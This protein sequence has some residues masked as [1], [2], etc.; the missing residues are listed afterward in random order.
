VKATDDTLLTPEQQRMKLIQDRLLAVLYDLS[1]GEVGVLVD[2]EVA[3]SRFNALGLLTA[4]EDEFQVY[5]RQ[6][7]NRVERK[8]ATK[9]GGSK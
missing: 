1:D 8:R 5:L 4:T 3:R 9:D 6:M 2:L 7:T